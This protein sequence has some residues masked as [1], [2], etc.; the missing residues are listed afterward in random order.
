MQRNDNPSL[1]RRDVLGLLGLAAGARFAAPLVEELT[2]AAG[3]GQ[4]PGT[5]FRLPA[6]AI[7]RTV[8]QDVSPAALRG[9]A[10]LMH[11][12]L[13]GG[14]Y[15]SPPQPAPPAP[16]AGRGGEGRGRGAPPGN[17]ARPED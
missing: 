11:E 1:S 12:H 17:P 10:T 15:S 16:P 5:M 2:L 6:G 8:L 9:R 3:L 4:P 7:V 14:F 13:L